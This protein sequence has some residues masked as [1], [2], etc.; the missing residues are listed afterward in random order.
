MLFWLFNRRTVVFLAVVLVFFAAAVVAPTWPPG[1]AVRNAII[2]AGAVMITICV[3]GRCW[4]IL[5]IDGKKGRA[6]V[7]W[8]PYSLTRNPLYLFTFFGTAGAGAAS[9]SLTIMVLAIVVIALVFAMQIRKEEETL[10]SR[11]GEEFAHYM[12]S[13][14]R[15]LPRLSGWQP[16]ETLEIR[17]KYVVETFFEACLF[18]LAIPAFYLIRLAQE[19]GYIPVLLRLP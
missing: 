19:S 5:Y 12:R 8:G 16:V 14:P 13:T 15:L 18:Y 17:P 3:L 1:G 10:L 9:G 11:F 7:D 4:S 2:I 6:V